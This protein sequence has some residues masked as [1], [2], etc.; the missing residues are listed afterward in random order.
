[1]FDLLLMSRHCFEKTDLAF[2]MCL[3][4]DNS[5]LLEYI[6]LIFALQLIIHRLPQRPQLPVKGLAL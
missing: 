4:T 5:D 2:F 1:M 6:N 3:Y